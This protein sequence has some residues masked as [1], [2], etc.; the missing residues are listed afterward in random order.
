MSRRRAVAVLVIATS[1]LSLGSPATAGRVSAGQQKSWGKDG[2]SLEQY[3]T[4]SAECAHVAADIDLEGTK[5]ARALVFW[6]RLGNGNMAPNNY[7]D[8]YMSARIN[9]EVQWNR[10]AAIMR[11]ELESCLAGR[12]YV[13]FELTDEQD[14]RLDQLEVGS[15]ERRSY[16]HSLASDPDVL[17]AQALMES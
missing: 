12:G 6:T 1:L 11:E 15:L 9:P 13:K 17:A 3:W 10:A 7:A 8:I 5:P 14:R 2:V 4:D 16:L